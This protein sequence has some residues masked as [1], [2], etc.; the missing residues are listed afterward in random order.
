MKH[1]FVNSCMTFMNNVLSVVMSVE[2]LRMA[3]E[4]GI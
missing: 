4:Q 1:Y 3:L 2:S